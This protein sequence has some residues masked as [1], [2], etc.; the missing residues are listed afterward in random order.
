MV[1]KIFLF[2]PDPNHFYKPRRPGPLEGRFAIV[3]DVGL[4]MRWT[5]AALLTRALTCGRR[6]RV[7]LTPRRRRQVCEKTRRRRR[8]ESPISGES[9]K[10]TVKTIACGNAGCSGATV[11]TTLVCYQHTAHEAAGAPG[12]RHSPR[13]R[14]SGESFMHDPGALRRGNAI[15]CE[16]R[17]HLVSGFSYPGLRFAPSG[18]RARAPIAGTTTDRTP[19]RQCCPLLMLDPHRN[20]CSA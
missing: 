10:E 8:Q 14:F 11:V 13:P 12:T 19:S 7:V 5:Q 18:Y 20:Q 16:I 3:T 1:V 4:G 9:T 6:S 2:P 15:G 17:D